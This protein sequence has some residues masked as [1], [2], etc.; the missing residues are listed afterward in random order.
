MTICTSWPN[1]GQCSE[2]PRAGPGGAGPDAPAPGAAGPP[3]WKVPAG[4][5]PQPATKTAAQVSKAARRVA[6][7]DRPPPDRS[8]V[9]LP[10]FP[11]IDALR[12][13]GC[14]YA[15]LYNAAFPRAARLA[16][17]PGLPTY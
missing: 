6:A 10:G 16:K 8:R 13:V 17:M 4:T 12:L 2:F 7:R 15:E 5:D 11:R 1:G 3:G 9:H 14:R